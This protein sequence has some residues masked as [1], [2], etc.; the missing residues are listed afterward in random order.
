MSFRYIDIHSHVNF[1]AFDADRE[2]VLKR[3]LDAGVAV[4]NVGTQQLTSRRAIELAEQYE[5]GVYAIVGL[6]PVHTSKSFHDEKELGEGGKE[7][8]SRSEAFEVTHYRD[9]AEHPKVVGIGE[10]GLDYYR[11]E[12]EALRIKQEE[13][14]RAQIELAISVQKPLMLH[15]RNGSGRSAYKDAFSILNSYFSIHNS[16][17][18]GNLHFFAGSIEEATPFLDL[19][20][21][22]SFTG[23]ITFAKEYQEV[24]RYLPLT[25]ILSETD[26]PYVAPAPYRGTRNE[27][28]H[29]REVVKAIANIRGE[30]EETVRVQLLQNAEQLFNI[31][32]S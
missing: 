5:K 30:E 21:T 23:V 19:G 1:T 6:H 9:L 18:K 14:F 32:L 17:L 13:A 11:I 15:L 27:P 26:A 24:I 22:F 7:F 3:A 25:S 29:V 31:K 28:L 12:S 10:C 20:Y 2:E 8:T 16:S 4:I